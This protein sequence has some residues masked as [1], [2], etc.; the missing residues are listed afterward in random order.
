MR[1][2]IRIAEV[3]GYGVHP[4]HVTRVANDIE[5]GIWQATLK[6]P[7]GLTPGWHDVRL[8]VADSALGSA[9][10]VAV[11]MPLGEAVLHIDGVGDGTTWTPGRMDL[12]QGSV[13]ALWASGL[14]ENADRNNVWVRLNGKRVEIDYMAPA[15][16]QSRQI[17][18]KLPAETQDGPAIVELTLQGRNAT[19]SAVEIA[20]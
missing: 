16:R 18:L 11:D 2:T 14:P 5:S 19:Y 9:H 17:N 15:G 7:P 3:G 12:S 8:R 13:L 20:H 1:F 4:I 10:A 6:L